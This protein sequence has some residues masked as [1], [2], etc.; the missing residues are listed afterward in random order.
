HEIIMKKED[1]LA[2]WGNLI[3]YKDAP[4]GVPN[5]IPLAIMSSKLKEKI[6]VVLS[7]EGADELMGGYGRIF[8]SPFDFEHRNLD[9]NFYD[10]FINNYE[11]VPRK[12][13]DKLINTPI[14]YRDEFDQR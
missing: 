14:G 1:Y 9:E 4:H 12:M 10:Y 3:R 5:E 8:R 11:Y 7:G 2:N 6:T 13:R